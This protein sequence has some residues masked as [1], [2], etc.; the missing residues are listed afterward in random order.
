M[1]WRTLSAMRR[2]RRIPILRKSRKLRGVVL[3]LSYASFAGVH[4]K[5]A[6]RSAERL[7][8]SALPI[9]LASD[10]HGPGQRLRAIPDGLRR[11]ETLVGSERM[12][13]MTTES[14]SRD[15]CMTMTR[16]PDLPLSAEWCEGKAPRRSARY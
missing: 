13:Q 7:V 3:Q 2:C 4:G 10:A 14:A 5:P 9:V 11:V 8:E 1:F 6:Q 16:L 12:L 15:Y